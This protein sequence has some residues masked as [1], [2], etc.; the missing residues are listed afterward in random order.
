[1]RKLTLTAGTTIGALAVAIGA[2]TPAHAATTSGFKGFRSC[3]TTGAFGDYQFS[4]WYGPDATINVAFSLTDTASDG[5][6]VRVR[7]ISKNVNGA[8][9]YYQWRSNT[10]GYGT[11]SRWTTTASNSMG[12]F[13]IG[14][15]VAR[16]NSDGSV[17][18]MC[19]SWGG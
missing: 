1:M 11:T 4:N 12:L 10:S 5:N 6:S 8:V 14:I 13:D 2:S 3:G 18:N 9:T 19:T 15:Q 7:M 17:R 16:I